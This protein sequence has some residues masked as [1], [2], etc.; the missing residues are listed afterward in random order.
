MFFSGF[1]RSG[2]KRASTHELPENYSDTYADVEGMLGAVLWDFKGKVRGIDN[3]L[4]HSIHL[5]AENK[6]VFLSVLAFE[7]AETNALFRLLHTDYRVAFTVEPADD[8]ESVG[9]MFPWD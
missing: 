9:V 1:R 5:V 2:I 6:G 4:L 7:I 3:A 8:L